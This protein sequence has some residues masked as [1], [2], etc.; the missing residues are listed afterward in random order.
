MKSEKVVFKRYSAAEI[1]TKILLIMNKVLTKKKILPNKN[2]RQ[3]YFV[4]CKNLVVVHHS[5]SSQL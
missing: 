4:D 2:D 5:T 1:E 3:Y